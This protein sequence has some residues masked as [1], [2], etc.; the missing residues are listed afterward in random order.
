MPPSAGADQ[1]GQPGNPALSSRTPGLPSGNAP[2]GNHSP[3][4]VDEPE[5]EDCEPEFVL[6]EPEVESEEVESLSVF[7]SLSDESDEEPESVEDESEDEPVP[8]LEPDVLESVDELPVEPEFDEVLPEFVLESEPVEPDVEF[9]DESDDESEP[10]R[11]DGAE[12]WSW[13]R[14]PLSDVS[15][16][17]SF[18][19][20][21]V[22]GT[23]VEPVPFPPVARRITPAVMPTMSSEIATD[24]MMA[25]RFFFRADICSAPDG[26]SWD[27]DAGRA[28]FSS[29]PVPGS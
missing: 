21:E 22:E 7:L 10:E 12:G 8:E 15:L 9:E 2:D 16:C 3:D 6:V 27:A 1:A 18:V 25:M 17:V 28:G 26:D 23:I 13:L 19:V 4:P 14:L 5:F 29:L 11:L 24:T 20:C